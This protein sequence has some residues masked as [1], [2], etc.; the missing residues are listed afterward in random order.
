[1]E[2]FVGPFQWTLFSWLIALGVLAPG[3]RYRSGTNPVDLMVE[4]APS[5]ADVAQRWIRALAQ[6]REPR[7]CRSIFEIAVTLVPFVAL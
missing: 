1:M 6:Y 5:A 2:L 4:K 7:P 3:A